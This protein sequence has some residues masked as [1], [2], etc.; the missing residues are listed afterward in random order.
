MEIKEARSY[1]QWDLSCGLYA[2]MH[3]LKFGLYS[4]PGGGVEENEAVLLR[5]IGRLWKKQA[6]PVTKLRNRVWFMK[7]GQAL[8]T[9]R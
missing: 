8:T 2:V 1:V 6:A 9:R 7:I 4:M 5:F 3:S